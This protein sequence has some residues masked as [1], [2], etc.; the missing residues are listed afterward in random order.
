MVVR[1]AN[2]GK[3]FSHTTAMALTSPTA[4]PVSNANSKAVSSD[5]P[6]FS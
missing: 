2:S 5:P 1:V 6:W 3:I 4:P